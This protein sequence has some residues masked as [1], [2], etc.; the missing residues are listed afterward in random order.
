LKERLLSVFKFILAVLLL[1]VVISVTVSFMENLRSSDAKVALA[2]GW[3]VIAYL[4]LHILFYEP[5]QV[6]DTAKKMTEKAV[7][8]LFPLVKI[9]GF[10]VPF[11]TIVAF[12]IYVPASKIWPQYDLL[13]LFVFLASFFF[14]MHM[15]FSANSL[16]GKQA[17]WLKE[18]YLLS[19]FLIYSVNLII[20]ACIFSFLVE[21]FSLSAFFQRI[22]EVAGAIYTASFEQLF[23]VERKRI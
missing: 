7:G 6:F 18:N 15:V 20:I 14:T 10:C 19:I 23:D 8:F 13:P 16:K 1:P 4:I 11:F 3:G 5:A 9:A 21:Y 17:G 12:V 22:G 2:F